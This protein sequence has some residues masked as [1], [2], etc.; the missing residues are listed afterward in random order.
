MY[1]YEMPLCR[2]SDLPFIFL[3]E[4]LLAFQHLS[5]VTPRNNIF[6]ISQGVR[7]FFFFYKVEWRHPCFS[8][9]IELINLKINLYERPLPR[10]S[11]LLFI[12]PPGGL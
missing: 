10:S 5:K 4:G 3:P 9:N 8:I 2:S 1:L 12:F 6:L 11:Y 7:A